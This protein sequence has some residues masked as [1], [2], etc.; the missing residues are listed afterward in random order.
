M[1]FS[2]ALTPKLARPKRPIPPWVVRMPR[3]LVLPAVAAQ[4]VFP[5]GEVV[6]AV[7]ALGFEVET[8]ARAQ[9]VVAVGEVRTVVA[10]GRP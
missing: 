2:V 1:Q 5:V 9:P 3:S 4:P 7:T 10:A 6:V 8:A